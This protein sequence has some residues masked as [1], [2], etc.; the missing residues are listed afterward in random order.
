MF[1]DRQH[2]A[3][4]SGTILTCGF[5][6]SK[7]P[8]RSWH[9]SIPWRKKVCLS[10]CIAKRHAVFPCLLYFDLMIFDLILVFILS[11]FYFLSRRGRRGWWWWWCCWCWCWAVWQWELHLTEL[12]QKCGVLLKCDTL[13]LLIVLFLK[14]KFWVDINTQLVSCIWM[15]IRLSFN[16]SKLEVEECSWTGCTPHVICFCSYI[17]QVP[18]RWRSAH[19]QRNLFLRR[20]RSCQGLPIPVGRAWGDLD[21]TSPESANGI[22]LDLRYLALDFFVSRCFCWAHLARMCSSMCWQCYGWRSLEPIWT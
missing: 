15:K 22:M 14:T 11:F 10:S 4:S 17:I 5:S 3:D 8:F 19:F 7:D 13:T 18:R 12:E 20:V 1:S 9:V 2:D 16:K 21:L 6:G